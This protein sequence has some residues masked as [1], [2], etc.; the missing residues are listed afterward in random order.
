MSHTGRGTNPGRNYAWNGTAQVWVP[1]ADIQTYP[2]AVA[3]TIPV[4]NDPF[5]SF[6][7][8]KACLIVSPCNI[9]L[10]QMSS[11]WSQTGGDAGMGIYD[12]NGNLLGNTPQTTITTGINTVNLGSSVTLSIA[13]IYYFALSSDGNGSRNL[14]LSGRV[15]G[16]PTPSVGISVPNPF[17]SAASGFPATIATSNQID[18]RPWVFAAA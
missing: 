11:F 9:V 18:T 3:D 2:L 7:V 15:S 14:S 1:G 10:T 6:G 13:E 8:L 17:S 4:F 12:K 5:S 16:T